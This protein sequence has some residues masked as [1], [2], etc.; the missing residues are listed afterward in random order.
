VNKIVDRVFEVV[1]SQIP[2]IV[3]MEGYA[4]TASTNTITQLAELCGIIKHQLFSCGYEDSREAMTR[5]TKA[6][7]VQTVSQMKKFNLGNG[8]MKKDSRYLLEVFQRIKQSFSDDNQ[9]DAYMH[10][11]LCSMIVGVLQGKVPVGNLTSYQQEALMSGGVRKHKGL[12]MAKAL[13]LTDDQKLKYVG[14]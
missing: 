6:F 10:A 1:K 14:W 9:A 11:W 8:A 7:T 3:V 5:G 12:S 2:D 13:K 4:F